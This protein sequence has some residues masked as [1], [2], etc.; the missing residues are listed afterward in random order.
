[1]RNEYKVEMIRITKN[2][3]YACKDVEKII[4]DYAKDGWTPINIDYDTNLFAYEIF[5]SRPV[6]E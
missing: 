2:R 1:M 3:L 6:K 4:N 5:F